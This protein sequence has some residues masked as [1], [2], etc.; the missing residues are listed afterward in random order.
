MIKESD[1]FLL[2]DS[3]SLRIPFF[4]NVVEGFR[5][6][7]VVESLSKTSSIVQISITDVDINQKLLRWLSE[8]NE[9]AAEDKNFIAENTSLFIENRLKLI[10]QELDGW[11]RMWK[12]LKSPTN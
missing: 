11:S 3:K 7:L 9:D 10:M 12:V 6:K 4:C 8:I 5:E 2:E 1:L